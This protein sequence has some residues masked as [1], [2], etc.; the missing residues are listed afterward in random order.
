MESE[1]DKDSEEIS[2]D[3]K[4][5]GP[6]L[7]KDVMKINNKEE[8]LKIIYNCQGQPIGEHKKKLAS[9]MGIL[10]KSFVP[11][12]YTTWHKVPDTLKNNLWAAVQ[13]ITFFLLLCI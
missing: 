6:A 2:F 11:I 8:R 13:V 4:G 3:K 9:Y 7:L 1:N 10:V 12:S 5:R